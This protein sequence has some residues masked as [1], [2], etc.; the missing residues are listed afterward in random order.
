V[1]TRHIAFTLM[2]ALLTGC[3]GTHVASRPPGEGGSGGNDSAGS[4]GGGSGGRN[5][6]GTGGDSTGGAGASGTGGA[7]G[8]SGDGGGGGTNQPD[9]GPE[10]DA[11]GEDPGPIDGGPAPDLGPTPDAPPAVGD[12][13]CTRKVPVSTL[14]ALT[15]SIAAAK[16]GDCIQVADGTYTTTGEIAVA[17][18]GT[19]QERITISAVNIGGATIDGSAGFHV[20]ATAAYV[21]IRGFK[22]NHAARLVMDLGSHHCALL[23]NTFELKGTS[24]DYL[25][26]QGLDHEIGYNA[27]QNKPYDG[28]MVQVDASGRSH[29]G[30]QRAYFHHNLWSKATATSSN[31]NECVATWGG[32]TRLEYNL[33]QECNGD[34]EIVT[35]KSSDAIVRYNTFRT[36][37]RGQLSLRYS[38]RDVIDGNFF[39]GLKGALRIYGTDHK[40]TNNYFENNGGIGMYISDGNPSGGYIQIERLLVANNT[41][42]N[43]DVR[44]RSGTLP[45]LTVTFANN[46]IRK[47]GGNFVSPGPGWDV[48][49]SGNIFFGTASA[50]GVPAGGF[51]MVDPKLA[52]SG[53]T[54]H[55][56]A[57]S[58]AIDSAVGSFG[59][60]EDMDGQPRTGKLDVGADE[61]SSAPVVRRPLM[62]S[63]VGPMAAP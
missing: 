13:T 53:G 35:L 16:P 18:A 7:G 45:P 62:P 4:G 48:N 49:Y 44:A 27:F 33:F 52:A 37:T 21:T 63:D 2:F 17:V 29:A 30:T 60:T 8:S 28:A 5:Q 41:L 6:G 10:D 23:R 39:F 57:G 32:F 55:L 34:P 40:V 56:Q 31:G 61:F 43:D 20:T 38:N 42:V 24:G 54:Q 15:A 51:R 50:T 26:V 9:A 22:L 14:P 59:L 1:N 25:Y 58:P 46:I 19:A 47:D 12:P 36:S 3:S 11:G